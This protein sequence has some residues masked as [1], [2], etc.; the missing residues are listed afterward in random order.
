VIVV[1]DT[2]ALHGDV[3][4]EGSW[5]RT[6][7][8]A[9]E[10]RDDL[11]VRTPSVVVEELV[12]QFP[13]RFDEI[14]KAFRQHR[15]TVRAYGFQ[16]PQLPDRDEEVTAYRPRLE[17]A[18][19][20]PGRS[21]AAP[22]T[23]AGQIAEWVAQRRKPVPGDGGGTVDAQI[24]LTA[25]EAVEDD[26]EVVLITNNDDDFADG[27]ETSKPHPVLRQDL[28]SSGHDEDS[29]TLMPRILDFNQEHVEPGVQA[30]L[31]AQALLGDASEHARLLAAIQDAVEWFSL[32][33]DEAEWAFENVYVESANVVAFD[34][35]TISLVRADEGPG[36]GAY[37]TV[38]A[39]GDAT[40]ELFLWTYEAHALP[41]DTPIEIDDY[42]YN[43]SMA[44]GRATLPARLLAEVRSDDIAI[45]IEEIE[46]VSSAEIFGLL[47]TWA[48][49]HPGETLA[50]VADG[51]DAAGQQEARAARP[52]GV[53]KFAFSG[54]DVYARAEFAVDYANPVDEDDHELSAENIA[55]HVVDLRLVDPNLDELELESVDLAPSFFPN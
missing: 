51:F 10:A 27:D 7:F 1:L 22:P 39:F 24:W 12:R 26:E 20:G 3:Y 45:A 42:D 5:A 41:D 36:G 48:D 49:D 28:I 23:S 15:H 4:A 6:L 40:L 25:V 35:E 30:T 21:I 8:A 14:D 55:E 43:E 11:E 13:E 32:D 46:P 53:S 38:E 37:L 52:T 29:I 18:L 9:A 33:L 19:T 16:L 54:D 34:V 44:S 47:D 17:A 31:A 2:N 50:L